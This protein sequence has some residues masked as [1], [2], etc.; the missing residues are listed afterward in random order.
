MALEE[1]VNDDYAQWLPPAGLVGE[2]PLGA[3]PLFAGGVLRQNLHECTHERLSVVAHHRSLDVGDRV[4]QIV[5]SAAVAGSNAGNA[6]DG[7]RG[8]GALGGGGKG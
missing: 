2:P 3:G 1:A 6:G 4:G 8:H 5:L 7:A